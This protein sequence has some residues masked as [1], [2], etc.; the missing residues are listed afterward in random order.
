MSNNRIILDG[1][2][3]QFQELNE[4]EL[5]N[6]E[7]FEVFSLFQ[8]FKNSNLTFENIQSSIVDGS[9]DGGIDSIIILIDDETIENITELDDYNFKKNTNTKIIISQCKK[10]KS[11]KESTLD[12]LI[13]SIPILFNLELP[14]EDLLKRFNVNVVTLGL[15]AR[16][17]WLK[18]ATNGGKTSL[19]FHYV[20]NASKI[21]I[22][23][24]FAEKKE[25]L[26]DITNGLFATNDTT[27]SNYSSKELLDYYQRHISSIL[28]LEFKEQPLF[29]SFV[30]DEQEQIGYIGMVLLSKYK[31]FLTSE[32][33]EIREDIFESNVRH[34]QGNVD[35]NKKIK[36][37]ILFDYEKD[38]WW[39]NNGIT[40]I[41]EN[42]TPFG[43][44]ISLQN[45]Q[46]V[47]GLQTSYSIFNHLKLDEN[48][49]RSVLVKIIIN[50]D[51]KIIDNIIASTN[52]QSPVSPTLLKATEGIQ[53][54]LE[55]FFLN[56]GY[57]YDRRKNYYKNQGKPLGK[58]F[59][60]QYTAQS[61]ESIAFSN[62][63][64]ARANP[65]TLLKHDASYKR[66][67][68]PD[69]SFKI[70]LNCCLFNKSTHEFVLKIDDRSIKDKVANFKLHLAWI[71]LHVLECKRNLNFSDIENI[72]LGNYNN[73]VFNNS[74]QFLIEQIDTYLEKNTSNIINIAKSGE[75][76]NYLKEKL[77]EIID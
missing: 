53:R 24:S 18:T 73:D 14:E 7:I 47:N 69:R 15:L 16:E 66:I 32:D 26:I 55:L 67:F 51:K 72:E 34:F 68:N 37:T 48:E 49:N 64:G 12:K 57:F 38:F 4:L 58:I 50:S 9:D 17:I 8:I 44:K 27:F 71:A 2:I 28:E 43:K 59:S 22:N 13:T 29:T 65:T 39:L 56:Q 41:A 6:S 46:I 62:P 20:T 23:Q 77:V 42:P 61:I 35:V 25:Q 75:F 21:E 10:E 74:V 1:C 36:E 3:Q 30:S 76:T 52:R 54:D 45:V 5:E 31:K 40:I 11:F 60:I 70:Y 63:H 33:N 19:E